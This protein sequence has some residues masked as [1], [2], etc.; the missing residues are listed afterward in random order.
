MADD[1]ESRERATARGE[2]IRAVLLAKLHEDG[3]ATATAL[4]RFMPP[5]ISLSEVAFQLDRLAE[6]GKAVGEQGSE[7]RAL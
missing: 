7:Y 6:E 4:A 1:Y 2:R 3:P 5:E